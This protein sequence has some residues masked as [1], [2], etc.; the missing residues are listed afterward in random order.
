MGKA[1]SFPFVAGCIAGIVLCAVA[2]PAH[3]AWVGSPWRLRGAQD[4]TAFRAGA[5]LVGTPK[6]YDRQATAALQ[7]KNVGSSSQLRMFLRQPWYAAATQWLAWMPY[8]AAIAAWKVLLVA[9]GVSFIFAWPGS[10]S[11][12]AL[13]LCWS[14]PMLAGIEQGQDSIWVATSIAGTLR[15]L[16]KRPLVAGLLLSACC[17]KFQFLLFVPLFIVVKREWRM[18][19]GLGIGIAAQLCVS[20]AVQG[21]GWWVGYY[22]ALSGNIN[23]LWWM[24]PTFSGILRAFPAFLVSWIIVA[25]VLA[26]ILWRASFLQDSRLALSACMAGA[27][28]AAPHAYLQDAVLLIPMCLEAIASAPRL[29]PVSV[30]LLSP[31]AS[32]PAAA[33]IPIVGPA[34]IVIP[35]TAM[36]VSLSRHKNLCGV[37]ETTQ[38]PRLTVTAAYR[39]K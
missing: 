36:L 21:W 18:A 4:A 23:G 20:T 6:L 1:G 39:G 25:S 22:Y 12:A 14:L 29:R 17:I 5:E 13:A 26:L 7:I 31:L 15:L 3:D 9:G 27:L 24:M 11:R 35:A 16:P 8:A 28:L 2:L 33:W 32:L 19:A 10:R 37:L 34:F 30:F 38:M